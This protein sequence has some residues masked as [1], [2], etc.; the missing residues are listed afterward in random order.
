[1]TTRSTLTTRNSTWGFREWVHMILKRQATQHY[2]YCG[3][4]PLIIQM[5]KESSDKGC[6]H[7]L[8]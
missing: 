5:L 3:N 6:I 2:Y 8:I 1:M 7:A 4:V